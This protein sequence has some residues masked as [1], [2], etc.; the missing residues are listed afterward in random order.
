MKKRTAALLWVFLLT[1]SFTV[2]VFANP[3]PSGKEFKIF[4]SDGNELSILKV[5]KEKVSLSVECDHGDDCCGTVEIVTSVLEKHRELVDDFN[6]NEFLKGSEYDGKQW[7]KMFEI[8]L[9][10]KDCVRFPITLSFDKSDWPE[11]KPLVMH[12]AAQNEKWEIIELEEYG[13]QYL[14]RFNSFSPVIF[15]QSQENPEADIPVG[16]ENNNALLP[17]A[18][19]IVLGVVGFVSVKKKKHA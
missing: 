2:N 13:N 6:V 5:D 14:A 3:S 10:A 16:N 12:Y 7:M 1:M 15:Y 9:I 4:N 18:A 8:D 19:V 11:G 17:I